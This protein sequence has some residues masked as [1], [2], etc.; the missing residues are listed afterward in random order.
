MQNSNF[1]WARIAGDPASK[2]SKSFKGMFRDKS[3]RMRARMVE[4]SAKKLEP[5]S[6]AV[7]NGVIGEDGQARA[8]FIGAVRL[9]L[10]FIMPRRKGEAKTFTPHHTVKPDLDKL[11]RGVKDALTVAGV[12]RDD[13]QACLYGAISKRWSEPGEPAGCVI[14]VEA[15]PPVEKGKT[16]GKAESADGK[17]GRSG[18]ARKGKRSGTGDHGGALYFA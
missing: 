12:W 3:G 7:V 2:G 14:I 9:S 18:V 17:R 15:L 5:W 11:V 8:H 16:H 13:A 6:Q 10:E 1:L 4:S